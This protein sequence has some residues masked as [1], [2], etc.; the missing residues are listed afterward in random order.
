MT[1]FPYKIEIQWSNEDESYLASVPA[2]R[3]C[4]SHGDTPDE[5][6][7]N[8]LIAAKLIIEIMTQE[9]KPLPK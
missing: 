3:Y 7:K 2:F 4:L 8:V 5:A 1:P 9:G 6:L